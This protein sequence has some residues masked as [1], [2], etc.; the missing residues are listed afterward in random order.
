MPA[1]LVVGA[2]SGIGRACATALALKGWR[3]VAAARR[4][5]LLDDLARQLPSVTAEALDVTDPCEVRRIVEGVAPLDVLVYASG[6]NV[7]D[8]EVEVLTPG[9]WDDIVRVNLTGAFHAVSAAVPLM[10]ANGGGLIVLIASV[11]ALSPDASGAAY[12]AAKRGLVGL[13]H[14]T[15]FEEHHHG[16]RVSVVHPGLVDTAFVDQ[17]RNPPPA[18]VRARA[19]HPD[20]VAAAVTMLAALPARAYVPELTILPTALQ[21][22]GSTT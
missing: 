1:A 5:S 22:M 9:H 3:V 14:A 20:D 17:R 7:A 16:I 4:Q 2:T 13:A 10:R 12:Q 11:S 18:E 21:T 19:L 8:R 15:T 6:L